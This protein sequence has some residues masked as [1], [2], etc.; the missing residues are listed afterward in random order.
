MLSLI[1]CTGSQ[2]ISIPPKSVLCYNDVMALP[3][4]TSDISSLEAR[5]AAL[6]D[7]AKREDLRRK[8]LLIVMSVGTV[9]TLGLGLVGAFIYAKILFEITSQIG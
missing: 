4:L 5:V 2:N 3:N 7:R 6:E 8:I 9:F 1:P